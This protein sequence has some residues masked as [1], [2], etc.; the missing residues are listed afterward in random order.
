[1]QDLGHRGDAATFQRLR[2]YFVRKTMEEDARAL[3][4]DVCVVQI[5]RW[6]KLLP[7]PLGNTVHAHKVGKVFLLFYELEDQ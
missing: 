1:M 4:M 6:G 5:T 3:C 7:M 2:N